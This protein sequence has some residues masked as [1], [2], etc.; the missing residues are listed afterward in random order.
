MAWPSDSETHQYPFFLR[1]A[2]EQDGSEC[3]PLHGDQ[4]ADVA[5]VGGGYAG[6]WTAIEIKQRKPSTDVAVLEAVL[7]GNGASGRNGGMIVP[8]IAKLPILE[9]QHGREQAMQ[10]VQ[11][12]REATDHLEAWSLAGG[13]FDFRRSGWLWTASCAAHLGSWNGLASFLERRGIDAMQLLDRSQTEEKSGSKAFSGS[14]FIKDGATVQ[15][16]KLARALRRRALEMGVRIYERSPVTNLTLHDRFRFKTPKGSL[17]YAK[18]VLTV[19]AWSNQIPEL[20]NSILVMMSDGA[21]S[22]PIPDDLKRLGMG[23]I[24]YWMDSNTFV[25]GARSTADGRL[26]VGVTGGAIPFGNLGRRMHYGPSDRL[27]DLYAV[28]RKYYPEL[29]SLNLQTSWRGAVDRSRDGLPFFGHLND[30]PEI[31]YGLGFSGNGICVT[32]L[33]G[34]ILAALALDIEDEWSTCGMVGARVGWLPREPVR[35]LGSRMVRWAVRRKDQQAALGQPQGLA[36]RL[37]SDF[38]P[39]GLISSRAKGVTEGK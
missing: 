37:L 10:I 38:V 24:P 34:K 6:L 5:I 21:V 20:N 1:Q 9:A 14:V 15:P 33:A 28:V 13:D 36:V 39:S 2:L 30:R 18:A 31:S 11:A 22:A 35:Y 17:R 3:F 16:G 8:L 25:S 27:A 32:P 4:Y 26:Y 23:N 19:N 29:R 12:S 7:C